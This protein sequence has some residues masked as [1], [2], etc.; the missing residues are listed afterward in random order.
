MPLFPVLPMIS[1]MSPLP[2]SGLRRDQSGSMLIELLI[3][4]TVLAIAVGALI[5]IYASSLISLRHTSIEGN[6]LTLADKQIEVYK[7]LAYANI[8]LDS[9]TIPSSGTDPYVTA[10]ASDSTIPSSS[11]Q[12]TGG[13]VGASACTA[14]TLAQPQCATQSW[15]GPDSRSYRVDTYIVTITPPAS[16]AG[17]AVRTVKQVTVAVRRVA[18]GVVSSQIWARATTTIDQSN[19]PA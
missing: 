6:A 11:G 18:S 15:T 13:T 1:P 8:L 2:R 19:P 3:A 4:M 7:S 9:S 5:S 14:P 10:N 12:V 16:S 17:G